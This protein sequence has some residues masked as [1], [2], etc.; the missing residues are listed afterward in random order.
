MDGNQEEMQYKILALL[1]EDNH[2]LDAVSL[3]ETARLIGLDTGLD[4]AN[5]LKMLDALIENGHIV[6]IEGGYTLG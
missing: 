1:R 3:G 6:A 2:T 4:Q 5:V